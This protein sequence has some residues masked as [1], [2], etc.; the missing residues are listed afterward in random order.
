MIRTRLFAPL[1]IPSSWSGGLWLAPLQVN[2][3]GIAPPGAKA[4][5]VTAICAEAEMAATKTQN[6][7][8]RRNRGFIETEVNPKT[9][10]KP[11]KFCAD[12]LQQAA[13][14]NRRSQK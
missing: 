2:W 5:L 12:D 9:N 7:T 14:Q 4:E 11:T 10:F 8:T 1:R 6:G 13:I 3:A